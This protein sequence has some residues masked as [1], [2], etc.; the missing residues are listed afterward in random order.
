MNSEF[1]KLQNQLKELQTKFVEIEEAYTKL[2]R[3]FKQIDR[4]YSTTSS[5]EV[6]HALK[7]LLNFTKNPFQN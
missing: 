7:E 6:I 5:L 1:D 3:R 4:L 2:Q